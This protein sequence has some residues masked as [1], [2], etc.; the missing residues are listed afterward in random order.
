MEP[1][2]IIEIGIDKQFCKEI[3]LQELNYCKNKGGY[4]DHYLDDLDTFI[5]SKILDWKIFYYEYTNKNL[6]HYSFDRESKSG[7]VVGSRNNYYF[8]IYP[9]RKNLNEHWKITNRK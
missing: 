4:L 2:N 6:N 7:L 9:K 3:F 1:K 5:K 8:S